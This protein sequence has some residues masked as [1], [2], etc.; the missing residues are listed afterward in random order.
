MLEL[1]FVIWELLD[2]I[3]SI[4]KYVHQNTN[5]FDEKMSLYVTEFT[6]V[7]EYPRIY[8]FILKMHHSQNTYRHFKDHP[9]LEIKV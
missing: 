8:L 2:K 4:D 6:H 5:V 7:W 1:K 9:L 3:Q